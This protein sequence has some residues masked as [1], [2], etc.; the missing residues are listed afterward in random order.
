[1][2]YK[3]S[4]D[5]NKQKDNLLKRRNKIDYSL[6]NPSSL[7]S[8]SFSSLFRNSILLFPSALGIEILCILS[9][10]IGES[11]GFYVFGF[12]PIGI[13]YAYS[14][15]FFV[16]GFTIFLII[17]G[18]Y[19]EHKNINL[20]CHD[21]GNC[22]HNQFQLGFKFN[23]IT[24]FKY[25]KNGWFNLSI[26]FYNPNRN[27]LLKRS[28]YLLLTAE[29]ICV[30]TAQTIDLLFYNFSVFLSIPMALIA[31]AF[32]ISLQQAEEIKKINILKSNKQNKDNNNK[33][34]QSK[35][36]IVPIALSINAL[37][38]ILFVISGGY[39][40]YDNT[41][42]SKY[43]THLINSQNITFFSAPDLVVIETDEQGVGIYIDYLSIVKP[44]SNPINQIFNIPS[45]RHIINTNI[46][47]ETH[48]EGNIR[49]NNNQ[50]I[51][52][53]F[54]EC[55]NQGCELPQEIMNVYM[56]HNN[57]SDKQI[58]EDRLNDDEKILF[59]NSSSFSFEP[60]LSQYAID[61]NHHKLFNKL[62]IHTKQKENI[63]AFYITNVK[64]TNKIK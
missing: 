63:E 42:N 52:L 10:I 12:N 17:I 33:K 48:P 3:N 27:H 61:N 59:V 50:S 53:D 29:S 1:L 16:A 54:Y 34:I 13:I 62:V 5:K 15:G 57:T 23:F 9:S 11:I 7:S 21:D 38:I 32:V 58:I 8:S 28:L 35:F 56:T 39:N 30:I 20:G 24:T 4:D 44:D 51:H 47:S 64:L 25:F 26:L 19:K 14:L 45:S 55:H 22:N 6:T 37:L 40:H 31:G 60:N 2:Q 43:H 46:N 36:K 18:R 49:F 41:A